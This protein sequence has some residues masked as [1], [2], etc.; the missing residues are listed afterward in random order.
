MRFISRS[1]CLSFFSFLLITFLLA[2]T[3][4]AEAS[5]HA[6]AFIVDFSESMKGKI[7]DKSKEEIVRE[8][9]ERHS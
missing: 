9:F 8:M 3:L 1:L 6:V 7:D 5:S 4:Q 2:S